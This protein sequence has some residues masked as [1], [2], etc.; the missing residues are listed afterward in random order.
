MCGHNS[1]FF[2]FTLEF[3]PEPSF[4][5]DPGDYLNKSN[6]NETAIGVKSLKH[7][8]GRRGTAGPSDSSRRGLSSQVT[9][10][11]PHVVTRLISNIKTLIIY[12]FYGFGKQDLAVKECVQTQH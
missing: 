10:F 2:Y 1:F 9:R 6:E 5:N 4:G 7:T 3:K 8:A 11:T 12:S